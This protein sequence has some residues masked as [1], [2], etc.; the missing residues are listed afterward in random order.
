VWAKADQLPTTDE[1]ARAAA[2]VAA[3]QNSDGGF[4]WKPGDAS[5]LGATSTSIRVLKY[6]GGSIKVI[7]CFSCERVRYTEC[8]GQLCVFT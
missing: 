3:L 8:E 4:S 6:T 7:S 2:Y 1:L 5:D